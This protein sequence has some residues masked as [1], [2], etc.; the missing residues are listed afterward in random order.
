MNVRVELDLTGTGLWVL[1]ETVEV[2]PGDAGR[3]LE[4]PA[5]VQA[6]WIRVVSDR[7]TTAT[8]WLTYR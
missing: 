6:R 5:D 1:Y 4:F 8:A 2:P 3:E 7:D